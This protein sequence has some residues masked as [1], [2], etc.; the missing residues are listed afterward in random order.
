MREARQTQTLGGCCVAVTMK[1]RE[2]LTLKT[3]ELFLDGQK[4]EP[5]LNGNEETSFFFFF[6]HSLFMY[7]WIISK[8]PCN[9]KLRVFVTTICQHWTRCPRQDVYKAVISPSC[10][11]PSGPAPHHSPAMSNL[12]LATPFCLH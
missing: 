12:L 2:S 4:C 1:K 11:S 3:T 5:P 10:I 7:T 9:L 8:F 6:L